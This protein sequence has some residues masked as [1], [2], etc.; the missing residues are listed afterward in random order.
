MRFYFIKSWQKKSLVTISVASKEYRKWL[1][2]VSPFS[3][4]CRSSCWGSELGEN[5]ML[6]RDSKGNLRSIRACG[7]PRISRRKWLLCIVTMMAKCLCHLV[8][9]AM[10]A[11]EMPDC[12]A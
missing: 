4:V 8:F 2:C 7:T 5:G 12:N 1:F 11:M 10:D 9:I 3:P 6:V